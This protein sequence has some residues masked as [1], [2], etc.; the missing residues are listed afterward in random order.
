MGTWDSI[1]RWAVPF[2]IGHAQR[3]N[4]LEEIRGH[5]T[6]AREGGDEQGGSVTPASSLS[7]GVDECEKRGILL[8]L[9]LHNLE[10]SGGGYH[11]VGI[12]AARRC[13]SGRLH[14]AEM[15]FEHLADVTAGGG[16]G[17]G[18]VK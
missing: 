18:N 9:S 4:D 11:A 12:L 5:L 7:L 14:L 13:K 10:D 16:V 3:L 2:L 17:E 1:S 15:E 8:A 6:R